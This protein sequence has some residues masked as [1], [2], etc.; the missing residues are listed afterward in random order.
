MVGPDVKT[1][2][3]LAGQLESHEGSPGEARNSSAFPDYLER[4]G[5]DTMK[6]EIFFQAGEPDGGRTFLQGIK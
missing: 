2:L 1:A 4:T 5:G 3:R 6:A